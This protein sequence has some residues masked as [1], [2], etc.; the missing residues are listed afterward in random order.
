M[1]GVGGLGQAADIYAKEREA[2][3]PVHPLIQKY[4]ERI[5]AGEDPVQLGREASNDPGVQM[6]LQSLNAGP[7]APVAAQKGVPDINTASTP[8][9]LAAP[10]T[11]NPPGGPGGLGDLVG[12]GA[13]PAGVGASPTAATAPRPPPAQPT[14]RTVADI[15]AAAQERA[16]AVMRP[17]LETGAQLRD[18]AAP[19]RPTFAGPPQAP[20]P[21]PAPQQAPASGQAP[22]RQPSTPMQGAPARSS[23]TP[24]LTR[25]DYAQVAPLMPAMIAGRSREE[26]QRARGEVELAVNQ[27]KQNVRAL[28]AERK[29]RGEDVRQ[30]EA[31]LL[32]IEK[33]DV[34]QQQAILDY[35]GRREVAMINA[36][37]RM[38]AAQTAAARPRSGPSPLSELIKEANALRSQLTGMSRSDK[39]VAPDGTTYSFEEAQQRLEY[40]T[41]LIDAARGG[42]SQPAV[43]RV[44]PP[45]TKPGGIFTSPKT[46]FQ[47]S[48]NGKPYVQMTYSKSQNKTY[49]FDASGKAVDVAPGNLMAT[50]PK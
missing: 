27:L 4:V 20:A 30:V 19:E 33:L 7:R 21:A 42:P 13:A 35:I 39:M 34:S 40:V 31:A 23:G 48:P 36:G 32:G 29:A 38:G 49:Y 10:G 9:S 1:Q 16:T 24:P 11:V 3:S 12:Q 43:S 15:N 26:V 28:V 41:G 17:R 47:Q 50:K 5:M 6:L 25:R 46:T 8:A 18:F 45:T 2:Q 22:A 44:A 14:G 37:A